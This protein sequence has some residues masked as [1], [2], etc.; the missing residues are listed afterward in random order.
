VTITEGIVSA[1]IDVG[2]QA[3]AGA[4][5]A[6]LGLCACV[7]VGTPVIIG[8]AGIV[9][10]VLALLMTLGIRSANRAERAVAMER[11]GEDNGSFACALD[12]RSEAFD[13]WVVRAVW[14]AFSPYAGFPLRTTD[15]L[16]D[17]G[18]DSLELDV[19][20]EEVA[21]RSGHSLKNLHDI[22]EG[23]V[24]L[25]GLVIFVSHQPKRPMG[26]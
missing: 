1:M 5:L 12:R 6:V 3:V 25:G 26:S 15:R 16:E 17:F 11:K 23:D 24:T 7:I 2:Q 20:I 8:A 4:I 9:L 13:P 10:M 19:L 21:E 14:D 18:I 22:W